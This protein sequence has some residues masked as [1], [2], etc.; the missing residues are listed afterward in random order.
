M[1]EIKGK[2]KNI[3]M[4]L[5]NARFSIDYY[6]REYKWQT[7]QL[8]ELIEDLTGKFFE[9]YQ[10][11]DERS[12]IQTYENYF[13]GSIILCEK[14]GNKY[15]IDG[16]Q[17]LTTL[18]LLLIYLKNQLSNEKQ[19]IKLSSLIFS[20]VFGKESFNIDVEERRDCMNALF[21]NQ[22]FDIT[23]VSESIENIVNRY[24]EIGNLFPDEFSEDVFLY[25]SDW[26]LQNVYLVEITA[27]SDEDA[28]TIFETMNDRGLSLNPL[29]MLKG[30]LL[31]SITDQ[32]KRNKAVDIWKKWSE[33]LRTL[34]KDEDTDAFKA[35]LR[36][37][38]AQTIRERKRGASAKDFDKIGTE[39]HRWLKDNTTI[40][41]LNRSEDFYNFIDKDMQFYLREY[42][43]IKNASFQ[44]TK[45]LEPIFFNARVAFT[46]QYPLLLAP[47]VPED[48]E[49][50]QKK[51]AYGFDVY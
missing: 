29:D 15:I 32:E 10:A 12:A 1:K 13:L 5:E 26:L 21:N 9:S 27:Y 45:G 34:G 2:E 28:Y 43:I 22:D 40:A 41:Q 47:L 36:S 48:T 49:D 42:I 6:Q 51:I 23:D 39:F 30:Y 20:D 14:N 33:K 24:Q 18:T 46:L 38:Y 50:N 31:A 8:Q 3:R 4:L 37:Q 16:Q 17:R 19:R 35:W 25:F 7:K 11:D 44:M